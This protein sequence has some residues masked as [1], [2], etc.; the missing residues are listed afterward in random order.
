MRIATYAVYARYIYSD[1]FLRGPKCAKRKR[2]YFG[3][4]NII[5]KLVAHKFMRQRP[6]LQ[7]CKG[8]TRESHSVLLLLQLHSCSSWKSARCTARRAAGL[9]SHV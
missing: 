6:Q 1:Q 5:C 9:S 4:C 3:A 2:I 7:L 8:T